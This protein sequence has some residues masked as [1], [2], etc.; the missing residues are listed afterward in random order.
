MATNVKV[1][2]INIVASWR[3]DT[4]GLVDKCELC[5]KQ[6]VAPSPETLIEIEKNFKKIGQN[7][8][9][10][11]RGECQ[12]V[13]H[14]TCIEKLIGDGTQISTCPIDQT[15]WKVVDVLSTNALP[16]TTKYNIMN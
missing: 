16:A 10:C 7:E 8:N 1:T 11:V 4:P 9:Q 6:F 12:H 3:F 13:F 5:S 14:K 2:G 15:P